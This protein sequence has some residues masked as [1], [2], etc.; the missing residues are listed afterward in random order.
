[1]IRPHFSPDEVGTDCCE[2]RGGRRGRGRGALPER[3]HLHSGPGATIAAS[4]PGGHPS[5][6]APPWP[7]CSSGGLG[8]TSPAAFPQRWEPP[9][10]PVSS[11]KRRLGTFRRNRGMTTPRGDTLVVGHRCLSLSKT[12]PDADTPASAAIGGTRASCSVRFPP[13]PLS[14]WEPDG[15]VIRGYQGSQ[16]PTNAPARP[17]HAP[18]PAADRAVHSRGDRPGGRRPPARVPRTWRAST[19]NAVRL[20]APGSSTR[21]PSP[22]A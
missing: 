9:G 17:T 20:R 12:D 7:R 6:H 16:S 5:I 15:P 11:C 3:V 18:R 13:S 22:C 8:L 4:G 21:L 14:A 1:M 19:V 10:A 2:E